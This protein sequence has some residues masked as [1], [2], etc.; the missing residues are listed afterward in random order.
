MLVVG[1][2]CYGCENSLDPDFEVL[3]NCA[4][5][6]NLQFLGGLTR[7]DQRMITVRALPILIS[8]LYNMVSTDTTLL[9]RL[10]LAMKK[11]FLFFV[12]FKII[13]LEKVRMNHSTHSIE[14]FLFDSLD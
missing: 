5:L 13:A 4:K 1:V 2:V 9:F 7:L 3:A 11:R 10:S 14:R 8:S 6:M 12:S